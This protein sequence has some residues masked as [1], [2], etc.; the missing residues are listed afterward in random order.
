MRKYCRAMF[1][2][3]ANAAVQN[4]NKKKT[5]KVVNDE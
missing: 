2:V 4:L 1:A 5:I 3:T